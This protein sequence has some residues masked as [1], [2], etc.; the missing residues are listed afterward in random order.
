MKKIHADEKQISEFSVS[1]LRYLEGCPDAL[2]FIKATFGDKT[3]N[4]KHSK[5]GVIDMIVKHDKPDW[6]INFLLN[7]MKPKYR[8]EFFQKYLE[9]AVKDFDDEEMKKDLLYAF[10]YFSKYENEKKIKIILKKLKSYSEP[11]EAELKT[12]N[13]SPYRAEE[14]VATLNQELTVIEAIL[15]FMDDQ[16]KNFTRTVTDALMKLAEA[17]AWSNLVSLKYEDNI[18]ATALDLV[19]FTEIWQEN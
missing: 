2:R 8:L 9:D 13:G 6:I 18:R 15:F 10:S 14:I 16:P 11:I 19:E 4:L 12:Y 1:T 7:L 5:S 17:K 3:Y